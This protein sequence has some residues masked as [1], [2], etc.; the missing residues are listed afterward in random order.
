MRILLDTGGDGGVDRLQQMLEAKGHQVIPATS[1]A[2]ELV[3]LIEGADQLHAAVV[4]QTS[5]G[6]AWPKL[7]RQLRKQ[8]PRVPVVLLLGPRKDRAWRLAILSGAF[9]AVPAGAPELAMHAL[10]RAL[11]YV[12]GKAVGDL[13]GEGRVPG[14]VDRAADG[15][16]PLQMAGATR[17]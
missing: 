6:K 5:L 12:V 7:L 2:E 17:S 15:G 4:S 14:A 1:A 9:E 10:D 16:L 8:A 3:A 13:F 11:S